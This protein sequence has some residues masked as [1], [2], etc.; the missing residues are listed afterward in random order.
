M[1]LPMRRWR[2]NSGY[3]G[4]TDQRRTQAGTIP[5]LKHYMERNL[6]NFFYS[7][8]WT[9]AEITT[10]LWFDAADASTITLNGSNVSQWND[11]S[12]NGRNATQTGTAQPLYSST[13]LNNKPALDFDGADDD[14][15]LSSV[16]DLNSVSQSWFI[17]AKRDNA[18]GRTEISFGI[19]NQQES[20]GLADIPRWTDN[21]M[22]SQLGYVAN[23]P[24]PVSVISDAPYINCVTGGAVQLS[25][26]NGTLIGTGTTQSLSN[27]SVLDGGYVGSGRAMSFFGRYFD[28]KISELI[29]IPSVATTQDRQLIE[30]YLAHK[31]GLTSNLPVDHPYKT[32]AP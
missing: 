1:V 32:T 12:G 26:T 22:Y 8:T 5:M 23:R 11:K 9:P 7:S 19:G 16:S 3:N 30:G 15:V 27:F 4:T 17:V 25:Y 28:G 29:I 6:D 18:N 2:L 21:K 31:W 10:A 20:N 24:S 13:G 14:L